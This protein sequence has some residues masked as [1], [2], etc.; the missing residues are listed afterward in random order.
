M[1]FNCEK[2][3]YGDEIVF[4]KI[5]FLD[6]C[7]WLFMLV[8]VLPAPTVVYMWLILY[9]LYPCVS[10]VQD[11]ICDDWRATPQQRTSER[12]LSFFWPI[13]TS[14]LGNLCL[15]LLHT[16]TSNAYRA[17]KFLTLVILIFQ[18]CYIRIWS[19]SCCACI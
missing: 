7:S 4:F 6:C 12:A 11:D 1:W 16:D 15:N 19:V 17:Q 10:A 3:Y 8:V 2:S 13:P 9:Y 14:R 18:P 5:K